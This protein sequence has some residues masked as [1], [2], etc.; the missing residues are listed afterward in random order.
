MSSE[1]PVL[2]YATT[3]LVILAVLIV[4]GANVD[5]ILGVI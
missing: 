2:D 4:C 1:P 5:E 3:R